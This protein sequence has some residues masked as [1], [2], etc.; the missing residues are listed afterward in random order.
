M[1]R[2]Q[3]TQ[4]GRL[5]AGRLL[6]DAGPELQDRQRVEDL[7]GQ[8]CGLRPRA[9]DRAEELVRARS[10]VTSGSDRVSTHSRSASDSGSRATSFTRADV[11]R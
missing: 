6:E 4:C 9:P 8:R 10:E 2:V 7:A 3:R 1:Q 11:S 5:E